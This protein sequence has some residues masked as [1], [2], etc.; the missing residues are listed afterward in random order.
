MS[1]YDT[2][3]DIRSE[4]P[5]ISKQQEIVMDDQVD[6]KKNKKETKTKWLKVHI[7]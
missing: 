2:F 5:K 7:S 6:L 1:A 4:I 3:K